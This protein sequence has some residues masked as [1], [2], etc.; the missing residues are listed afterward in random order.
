[1]SP[2]G[3]ITYLT[4][5]DT[6]ISYTE[7]QT[8]I[9]TLGD[10]LD[11]MAPH[12]GGSVPDEDSTEYDEWVMWIKNK[13]EEYARRGFWRRLL[14][15]E[16]ITLTEGDTT[17]VLPDRF[18]KP[19]GL[20]ML[21]VTNDDGV[22]V[23]WNETPNSDNQTIFIEMISDP[24]S[25]NFGKWQMRFENEIEETTTAIIWYF[26]M[27]PIPGATTD[28]II[29]PGDM[30]GFAALS[31]YFRQANQPGSQDDAKADA[32]NRFTEYMALEV[33]P[34][35]SELLTNSEQQTNRVDRLVVARNYYR[36]RP[37]RNSRVY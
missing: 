24:D 27:P 7:A 8:T 1:M 23:D 37:S 34:D 15:R 29:L 2:P 18:H 6:D 35:K 14:T 19:N 10:I 26:A 30:I 17:K 20:Y 25:A 36:N 28:K 21:I 31:E 33:I 3:D 11:F 32:E 5:E 4:K 9:Q 13:Y 22:G 12:A 16:E